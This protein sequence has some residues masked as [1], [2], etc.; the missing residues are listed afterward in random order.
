MR[1]IGA[2]LKYRRLIIVVF[3]AGLVAIGY[4]LAF[5]LRFEFSIESEDVHRFWLT[6]PLVLGL[7]L[8]GFAWWRLYGG[9]WRYVSMRDILAILKA[10]TLTS[11][12]AVAGILLLVDRHFPWPIFP[13]DWGIC[14]LFVGGVRLALR[15]FHE[16]LVQSREVHGRRALIV[17]AG[18]AGELLIREMGRNTAF[19]YSIRGFV[20]DDPTK[21]GRRLH[22]IEVL[23]RI[24]QIPQLCRENDIEEILI[25][26]PSASG[27]EMRR[28][29]DACRAAK[30]SFRTLPR[31]DEMIENRATVPRIRPVNIEDLL[32][33]EPVEIDLTEIEKTISGKRVFVTGGG[34]SIGSELCRQ[35]ARF[36]PAA[37]TIFERAENSLFFI[38]LELRERFPWLRLSAVVGDVTDETRM[39]RT[40][41]EHA[42]EIV[43]HAAAHKHV[44]LMEQNRPEAVK[45]NVFGTM[46]LADLASRFQ[47]QKFVMIS[48][49]KAVRPTSL[50]G[51]TKRLAETYVQ[52]LNTK[53]DTRF[54]TVRF[55][56]VLGSEG[57]VL[58][59]FQKQLVAG[60]PI[61]VTHPDM[62]RYFMTIP[63]ACQL[64]LQAAS[65]GHGGEIFVLD[66][67]DPVRIVDL[68]K[69]LITLSGLEPGRDIEIKFTGMRPGEKLFEELLNPETHVLP[70][71]HE[72]IMVVQAEPAD[73]DA[74]KIEIVDLVRHA[75]KGDESEVT[76]RL[77]RLVPGYVNGRGE[78][79]GRAPSAGQILVVSPSP[80]V[81][82][83][84]KRILQARYAVTDS[85]SER[86]A[87]KW[88]E[89]ARPDLVIAQY[90]GTRASIRRLSSR[91]WEQAR[92]A[93]KPSRAPVVLLTESRDALSREDAV[94]LGADDRI[95]EP[96]P[97]DV[98][99]QTVASLLA[100]RLAS[101]SAA[102]IS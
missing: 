19:K 91:L 21:I 61:T 57:S 46:L 50:M 14:L 96:F 25:A 71:R 55:G 102:P 51:A 70:T 27:A 1:L 101:Q 29:I 95:Y 58:Q 20:D 40:F 92:E 2:L 39:T 48:T 18:N 88:M 80:Y 32:R 60:G 36:N 42:P 86:A 28:V 67:G 13:I 5:L 22:G 62:V 52:A 41:E 98:V 74:L 65:Q 49:D 16:G 56:N 72:K 54:M 75:R 8:T 93:G 7:R 68:A 66:M 69:D 6:L 85:E 9:L 35:I 37:L 31:V 33:R 34:G 44:P 87:L 3:H 99:E 12:M 30:V 89:Q 97:V 26:V 24:E 59:V 83:T 90:R 77:M 100:S 4:W 81:R 79:G 38:D 17:G 10:V 78:A 45:N 82:T 11:T 84:V 15:A 94:A 63:E 76:A 64:V 43:F 23:G 47:V 53:T 73:L